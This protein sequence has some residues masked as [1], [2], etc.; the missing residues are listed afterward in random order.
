ME[1][2][3]LLPVALK[4]AVDAHGGV[5]GKDGTPYILHPLRLMMQAKDYAEQITAI[6]HDAVEDTPLTL[7]HLEEAGFP[8]EI[9]AAIEAVTKRPDESYEAF[10]E[11][12]ARN[13][14]AVRV[15]RL[16]LRDN[17]NVMRLAELGEAELVRIARY[18]RALRRLEQAD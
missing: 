8:S 10:I 16:D 11:R 2:R 7:K 15:K 4:M 13:P 12:I 5:I 18:H 1:Y 17:L 9:V 14:L 6:L 3:D